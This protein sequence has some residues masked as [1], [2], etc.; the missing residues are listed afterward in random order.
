[1][2]AMDKDGDGTIDFEE[3]E[4]WWRANGGDLESK[5]HLAMTINVEGGVQLLLV[6]VCSTF[7]GIQ[8]TTAFTRVLGRCF[9]NTG[10]QRFST[11]TA[12]VGRFRG[13]AR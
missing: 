7:A 12:L 3:F 4:T 5:R 11:K 13:G 6:S 2:Q 9:D 10:S 1:M 8:S